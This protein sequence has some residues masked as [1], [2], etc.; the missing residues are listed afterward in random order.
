MDSPLATAAEAR[1]QEALEAGEDQL[2]AGKGQPLDME[3]YFAAPSSLRTGFSLLKNANV[4]PPE[5]E[6]FKEVARLRESLKTTTEPTRLEALT[7]ELRAREVE[8]AIGLERIKRG[9]KADAVG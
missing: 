3:S 4:V 9:L 7:H 5:V 2:L 8:L 1:I 6:A